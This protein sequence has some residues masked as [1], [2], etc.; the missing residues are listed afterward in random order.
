MLDTLIDLTYEAS[1]NCELWPSVLDGL[2]K[3]ADAEGGVLFAASSRSHQW[4]ASESLRSTMRDFITE[5]WAADNLRAEAALRLRPPGFATDRDLLSDHEIEHHPVYRDFFRPRGLGWCVGSTILPLTGDV[6][7][8]SLE[9]RFQRGPVEDAV[10]V[11]LDPMRPHLARAALLAS[12]FGLERAKGTVIGLDMIGLAAAIITANGVVV[13]A[14]KHLEAMPTLVQLRCFDRLAL[15]DPQANAALAAALPSLGRR[16]GS[17]R[18]AMTYPLKSHEGPPAIAHLLPLVASARDVFNRGDALLVVSRVGQNS[19]P[20][21]SLLEAIFDLT[22]S[23]SRVARHLCEG[24]KG[25]DVALQFGLSHETVRSHMK[26]IFRKTGVRRQ[27]DL[28]RLVG[29]LPIRG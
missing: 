22:P 11:A 3:I 6:L 8:L 18:P 27:A 7:V 2:S 24:T 1:V 20:G 16:D 26:A 12:R 9:R 21:D 17:Q 14:N 5:G 13:A 29:G 25:R 4:T 28:I 10:K 15:V 19:V 23:E